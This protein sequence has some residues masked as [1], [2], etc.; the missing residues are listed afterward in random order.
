[1]VRPVFYKWLLPTAMEWAII[2]ALFMAGYWLNSPIAWFA[3]TVVLG[4]RQH[5]LAVLGHE[6]AHYLISRNRWLN[7]SAAEL[8]CF[9]PLGVGI[10][11]YRE[12][13]FRHH[14]LIGTPDDAEWI[15]R[16]DWQ[17]TL[18][19][20]RS[21]IVGFFLGDI[22]GLGVPGVARVL[23]AVAGGRRALDW[24]GPILFLGGLVAAFV[25][26]GLWL[27]PVVWF[28][29][30]L[31]SFW[32]FFRL[33]IWTEHVGTSGTHR[34][35]ANWWQRWFIVPH[36]TWYHYEHHEQASVPFWALPLQRRHVSS[37]TFTIGELFS[38]YGYLT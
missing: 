9:W 25:W 33:R 34:I 18:P 27:V 30:L 31:T 13:H 15:D 12:H 6:G 8:L 7:D 26:S 16:D 17:W 28:S 36:N 19:K 35:S 11:G 14:R 3:V 10:G 5:A 24:F 20:S 1:M 22:V 38:L 4:S 23:F 2:V 32:A 29:A 37:R 21:Q